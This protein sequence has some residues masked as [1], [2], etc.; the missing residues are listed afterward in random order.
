MS[1]QNINQYVFRKLGLI[2]LNEVTDISLTSDEKS[3]DEEV[4]FSPFLIGIDDGNRMPFNFDFNNTGT[5]LC[6]TNVCSFDNDVIISQNYWNPTDTDPNYCPIVTDL[7]DVGLT[8]IDNGLVKKISGETIQI[9]TGLYT[10]NT[11]KFKCRC[12][13]FWHRKN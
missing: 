7:C 11:D 1:Y 2:P 4:I 12:K 6:T 13:P 5:T 9:T 10:N 8:G 3:Y